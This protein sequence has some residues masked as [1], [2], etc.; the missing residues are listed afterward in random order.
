MRVAGVDLAVVRP[1]AIAVLDDCELVAYLSAMEL[2]EIVS[3]LSPY[4]PAVVAV[5]A[6]LSKPDGWLR[7][8][9][10]ELR[11]LGYRLLPP[12]LGPMAR[13]TERGIQ[14]A[15]M[16]GNAIEVHPKTSLRAMGLDPQL[17]YS[18]YRPPTKDHF[19]AVLAALTALAYL[20]G[21]YRSIGPF[22][23]PLGNPCQYT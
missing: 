7:D 23:L 19:D 15:Q 9:E 12:L 2:E 16:L 21:L 3:A 8:V 14:L 13:L 17:V 4:R 10:R 6:P 1:S 11:K 5:D 20:K 22:V 18:R